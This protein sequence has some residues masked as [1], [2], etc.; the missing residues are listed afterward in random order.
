MSLVIAYII[1]GMSFSLG[2][3]IEY[4]DNM[5]E[6]VES[7]KLSNLKDAVQLIFIIALVILAW[8]VVLFTAD[9]ELK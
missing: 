1:I 6:F 4:Y 2:W 3:I 5:G 8:P 9:K 7:I